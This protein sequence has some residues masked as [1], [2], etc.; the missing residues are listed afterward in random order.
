MLAIV[1][2]LTFGSFQ[3]AHMSHGHSHSHGGGHSHDEGEPDDTWNLYQH[4]DRAEGL[5]GEVV[6]GGEGVVVSWAPEGSSGKARC[7]F[8]PHARRLQ[9]APALRS[10]A[11]EQLIVKVAFVAP[12]SVRRIMVV[13]AGPAEQ[14]PSSVRVFTGA[15]AE[16]LDFDNAET[17]APAQAEAL[18]PNPAGEGY[19][20]CVRQPFTNIM[21]VAFFFPA[22]HGEGDETGVAYI[23]MQG[24]HTHGKREV[25]HAD[26]ELLCTH[27]HNEHMLPTPQ[28]AGPKGFEHGD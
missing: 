6:G 2:K 5:N 9:P 3:P 26:Y 10:D 13:G 22:N 15:A 8:K 18:A 4:I 1:P 25:V 27:G 12:V 23:G 21:A 17:T 7:V 24:D 28:N 16:A 11:D 14:H 20:N 19:F